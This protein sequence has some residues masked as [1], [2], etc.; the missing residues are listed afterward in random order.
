MYAK[1]SGLPVYVH[2]VPCQRLHPW[3]NLAIKIINICG[4]KWFQYIRN[5][6]DDPVVFLQSV[7]ELIEIK[8]ELFLLQSDHARRFGNIEAKALQDFTLADEL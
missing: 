3:P 7:C 4:Q 1:V 8:L 5:G 6:V 2:R